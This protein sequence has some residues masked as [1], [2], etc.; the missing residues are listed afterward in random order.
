MRRKLCRCCHKVYLPHPQTY[1]QQKTCDEPSCRA[2]RKSQALK[3]W[4][5]KNPFYDKSRENKLK[6]WR[7]AHSGYWKEW[8]QLHPAYAAGNRRRQ[9]AR[10]AEKRGFLAK[11]NEWRAFWL[12]NL[13]E[14]SEIKNL[15]DLAKRNEWEGAVELQIEGVL[16][17]LRGQLMLA[18][19]NAIDRKL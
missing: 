4:R 18:K 15:R 14:L 9:K 12:Q 19:R 6:T 2:W 7:A 10:D 17:Y 11:R 1:R 13:Y 5:A 16:G 8:R 3:G